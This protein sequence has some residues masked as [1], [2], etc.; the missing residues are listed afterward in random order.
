MV[1]LWRK[2]CTFPTSSFLSLL[3]PPPSSFLSLYCIPHPFS[4]LVSYLFFLCKGWGCG[5]R[6]AAISALVC[7]YLKFLVLFIDILFIFN[8]FLNFLSILSSV[9]GLLLLFRGN[10]FSVVDSILV[11]RIRVAGCTPSH[12]ERG[13]RLHPRRDGLQFYRKQ[14]RTF[15]SIRNVNVLPSRVG[16]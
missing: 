1:K 13:D 14:N 5:Y 12:L 16:P 8:K 3:Q 15:S 2:V 4:I 9:R 10:R 6:H 11:P 7:W